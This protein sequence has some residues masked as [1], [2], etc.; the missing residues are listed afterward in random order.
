MGSILFI[1]GSEQ[2]A[3]VGLRLRLAVAILAHARSLNQGPFRDFLKET[4]VCLST[5]KE[6]GKPNLDNS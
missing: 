5:K 4:R 6:P 1:E 2:L 3:A